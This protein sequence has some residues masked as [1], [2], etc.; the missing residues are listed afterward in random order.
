MFS[1]P[2]QSL[3]VVVRGLSV[4]ALFPCLEAIGWSERAPELMRLVASIAPLTDP[5]VLL[6]ID[7][8]ETVLPRIGV[9][10]YVRSGTNDALRWRVLFAYLAARGLASPAK[11]DAIVAWPGVTQRGDV[12]SQ[13]PADLALSDALFGGSAASVFWRSI[14]HIKVSYAP[15]RGTEVK[16]YL[17]FG[18]SWI[19]TGAAA[20]SA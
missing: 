10:F 17:V 20:S 9:E 11:L 14:N 13:W 4:P 16:G 18:H 8:A 3:R 5:T 12:G 2:A 19:P 1:R 7:V 6:D 15:D